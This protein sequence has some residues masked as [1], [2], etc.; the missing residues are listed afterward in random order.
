MHNFEE[1]RKNILKV[2]E[3]R[4]S[5][6]TGSLGVKQAYKYYKGH[7]PKGHKYV[8]NDSQYSRIIRGINELLIEELYN[9][10]M[11]KFPYSM[12]ALE[13]REYTPRVKY[14]NGNIIN[15][16]YIDWNAT[17]KLWFDDEESRNKKTIVRQR[18]SNIYR[19]LYIKGSKAKY[20]NKKFFEFRAC[21]SLRQKIKEQVLNNTINAY[22]LNE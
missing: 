4:K 21:R 3:S 7:H 18:G 9:A 15:T 11:I 6:I 16:N 5:Y 8:L 20:N 14:I 10:N 12:G 13:V 1:Y 22:I 2:S 19:I 17:L